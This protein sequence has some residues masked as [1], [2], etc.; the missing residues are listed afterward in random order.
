[1]RTPPKTGD[2]YLHFKGTR[3]FVLGYVFD[4]NTE[5][6][7][8]LYLPEDELGKAKK[9]YCCRS[10]VDFMSPVDKVKYPEAKQYWRFEKIEEPYL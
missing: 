9:H 8:V 3:Y 6:T 1:M 4:A 5:R 10:L 7:K 2:V